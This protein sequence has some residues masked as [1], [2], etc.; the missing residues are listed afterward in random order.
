MDWNVGLTQY[1]HQ[2]GTSN[3][4]ASIDPGIAR[5]RM[6]YVI[7][8]AGCP[9]HRASK[10]QTEIAL[11]TTQSECIALSQSMSEVLPHTITF[12]KKSR[13]GLSASIM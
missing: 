9:M 1:M 5:S 2:N 10:M 8:Y 12:E 13:K 7:Q 4:T 3:K 6:G 11:S